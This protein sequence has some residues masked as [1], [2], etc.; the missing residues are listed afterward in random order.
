ME[1]IL[2]EN[3]EFTDDKLIKKG[4]NALEL[5]VGH[6]K[7]EY[8][9]ATGDMETGGIYV[10]I[11]PMYATENI[12]SYV[13]FD[14]SGFKVQVQNLKRKSQKKINT[15]LEKVKQYKNLILDLFKE[16]KREEILNLLETFAV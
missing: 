3:V 13:L 12:K 9:Y 14:K 10:Y 1:R 6:Q 11:Q 4:Y 8:N 16:N 2:L 15:V 5:A 7:T